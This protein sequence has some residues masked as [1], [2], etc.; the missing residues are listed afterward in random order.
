MGMSVKL[1]TAQ[2][3][4]VATAFLHNIACDQKELIPPVNDEGEAAVEFTTNVDLSEFPDQ[5]HNTSTSTRDTF[6]N[7]Y[8]NRLNNRNN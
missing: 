6:I 4:I 8:F 5:R 2:A 1:D 7:M 3:V